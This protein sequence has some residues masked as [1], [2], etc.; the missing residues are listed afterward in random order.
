MTTATPAQVSS[1]LGSA[2][3]I[4]SDFERRNVLTSFV[5]RNPLDKS[6]FLAVLQ[7]I[8]GMDSDFEIRTVLAAIAKRMPAD[9]ELI[10]RYRR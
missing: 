5:S 10:N 9:N 8:D 4:D 3:K 7:A 2:Q 6:G 1:Y